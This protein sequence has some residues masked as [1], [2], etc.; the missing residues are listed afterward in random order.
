MDEI[1]EDAEHEQRRRD[2]NGNCVSEWSNNN[3]ALLAAASLRPFHV[4]FKPDKSH[5]SDNISSQ[6]LP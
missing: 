1:D 6:V 2:C 3:Q 4:L 5:T